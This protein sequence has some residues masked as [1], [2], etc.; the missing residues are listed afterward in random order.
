MKE[1]GFKENITWKRLRENV[2][3]ISFFLKK[4]GLRKNDRVAGYVPNTIET[5]TGFL[6]SAKNGYIWSSCSPDFGVQGLVDRFRQIEP[7]VL[8]TCDYYYYNGKKIDIL[9][10][11]PEILKEIPTIKKVI[12]FN[13]TET[14]A[15]SHDYVKFKEILD[16]SDQDDK[17]E[18]FDFNQPIYILYSSGT[19]GAPKCIVHGAGNALI[20]HKKNF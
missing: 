12:V 6:A 10:R 8:F 2:F 16:T 11:I 17:F 18:K 3:K 9:S 20:E 5:V 7:K 14:E 13:Y 19:T 15:T 4:I 1:C